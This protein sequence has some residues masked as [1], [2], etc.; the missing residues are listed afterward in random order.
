ME[1][2]FLKNP[3]PLLWALGAMVLLCGI[4]LVLYLFVRQE[5]TLLKTARSD[6]F[7]ALAAGEAEAAMTAWESDSPTAEV[8]HRIASAAA[9]LTMAA[10]TENTI[11]LAENLQ[12]TGKI[13]LQGNSL[14]AEAASV[15]QATVLC[16]SMVQQVQQTEPEECTEQST[17]PLSVPWREMPPVSRREGLKLAETMTDTARTLHSAA[18]KHLVYTCRNVYVMLSHTGGVPWEMAVYTPVRH[19]PSYELNVCTFRSGRFLELFLPRFLRVSE[20]IQTTEDEYMFRFLYPCG[21]GQ[22]RVD[23]RTDTGRIIGLQMLKEAEKEQSLSLEK[24]CSYIN[25]Q[26]IRKQL[27]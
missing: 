25:Y 3:R 19:P 22:V 26:K 4:L 13:L 10:P 24:D 12:E 6:Q 1:K 2:R 27:P 15:L 5:N 8:Y 14:T 23:V 16:G 11:A 17:A 9:Y 21:N 18:G 20:P 7:L